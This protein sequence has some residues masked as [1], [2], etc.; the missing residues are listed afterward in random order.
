MSYGV[1][2]RC[3]LD[4]AWVWLWGRLAAVALIRPLAWEIPHTI[5]A[6]LKRKKKKKKKRTLA[7]LRHIFQLVLQLSEWHFYLFIFLFFCFLFL[8][9]HLR[10]MEAPRLGVDSEL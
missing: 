10:H 6:A 4:P 8:G 2:H 3:S 7:V 1:G 9:P 5:G